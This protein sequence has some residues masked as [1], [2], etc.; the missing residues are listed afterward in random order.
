VLLHPQL[1]ES[2]IRKSVRIDQ[3]VATT[4]LTVC[5]KATGEALFAALDGFELGAFALGVISLQLTDPCL[6]FF[7]ILLFSLPC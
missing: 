3:L 1:G 6:M 4:A 2:A 5:N 7:L